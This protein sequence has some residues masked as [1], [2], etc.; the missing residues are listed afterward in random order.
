MSNFRGLFAL[1][2][3]SYLLSSTARINRQMPKRTIFNGRLEFKNQ[4]SFERVKGLYEQRLENF[5]K[6]DILLRLEQMT[7][8][9]SHCLTIPKYVG[10]GSEK[11]W[12]NTVQLL[13][14]LSQYAISGKV[15]AWMTENG[16]VLLSSDIEPEGDKAAIINYKKGLELHKEGKQSEAIEAFDKAI[17][18][19]QD[20]SLAL[21]KR[22][23]S[24]LL[25]GDIDSAY[26]DFCQSIEVY[27]ENPEAYL[28]RA[29]VLI[30]KKQFEEAI[31]DLE[32]TLKYSV[33]MQPVFWKARRLKGKAHLHLGQLDKAKFE[34]KFFSK[35]DYTSTDPNFKWKR[36][37]LVQYGCLLWKDG[38]FAGAQ[39]Q[40]KQA[41][42]YASHTGISDEEITDLIAKVSE[43]EEWSADA[44]TIYI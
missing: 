10:E 6:D 42:L 25:M 34:L 9:D 38:D 37:S 12:N 41:P 18:I 7:E 19:Y 28:G 13:Q 16:Q 11:S 21:E 35:R 30:E 26:A 29:R 8:E 15:Q 3:L 44:M 14:Y 5:Y 4:K 1:F 33:P 39:D 22:A 43:K 40:L 27:P 32:K 36:A 20:H 17:N 23:Y 31:A 2:S 24:K